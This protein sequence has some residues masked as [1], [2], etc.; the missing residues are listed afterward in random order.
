MS[1]AATRRRRRMLGYRGAP[2]NILFLLGAMSFLLYVDRVNL[3]TAAGPIMKE[4]GLTNTQLGLAFSAFG[5]SYLIFQLVGGYLS[6]RFGSRAVLLVCG[7]SWVLTTLGTALIDGF[8]SL[9][10][11]RF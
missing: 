4:L 9:V 11:I 1:G 8:W 6:D 2:R 7:I 10:A 3:S 5:Y